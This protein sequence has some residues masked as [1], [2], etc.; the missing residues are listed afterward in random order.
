MRQKKD[1]SP[2]VKLTSE[3]KRRKRNVESARR[4]KQRLKN[5]Y[6]WMRIQ[7]EE[8]ESRIKQLETEVRDLTVELTSPP[9][10]SSRKKAQPNSSSTENR[11]SWFGEP[12]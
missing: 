3:D 11:P 6:N 9:G 7:A 2:D 1:Q 8:N 10:K 12:F 5:E 4:H